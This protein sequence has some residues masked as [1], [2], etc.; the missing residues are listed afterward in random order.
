MTNGLLIGIFILGNHPREA[1][2]E[3][4]VGGV[5]VSDHEISTVLD[6]R[7]GKFTK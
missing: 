5:L 7:K 6:T 3:G 1:T 2:Q 4:L